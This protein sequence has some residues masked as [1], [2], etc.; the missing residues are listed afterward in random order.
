M[1]NRKEIMDRAWE[2]KGQNKDKDFGLCLRMAWAVFS[3]CMAQTGYEVV[4]EAAN[5][6]GLI[7]RTAWEGEAYHCRDV[8]NRVFF[9]RKAKVIERKLY[10][11]NAV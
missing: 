9:D 5:G 8:Y 6:T 3:G 2:I 10:E 7:A 1:C 4:Y 11:G